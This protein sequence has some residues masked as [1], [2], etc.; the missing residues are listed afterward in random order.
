MAGDA[1]D[2]DSEEE[3]GDYYFDEA[4]KNG[5]EKLQVDGDAGPIVADFRTGEKSDEDPG[6]EG[7]ARSGVGGDEDDREPTQ[8]CWKN[9]RERCDCGEQRRGGVRRQKL[10]GAEV[11]EKLC[12]AKLKRGGEVREDLRAREELR[13]GGDGEHGLRG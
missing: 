13:R 6:R 9:G 5:A 1:D 11:R 12:G 4:E 10:R 7:T 2:E 8:N 3:R